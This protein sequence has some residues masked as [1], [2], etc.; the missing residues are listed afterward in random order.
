VAPRPP[1]HCVLVFAVIHLKRVIAE[2]TDIGAESPRRGNLLLV[3]AARM[4]ADG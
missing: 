4:N 3:T 1:T 2:C